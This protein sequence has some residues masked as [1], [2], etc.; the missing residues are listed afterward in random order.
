MTNVSMSIVTMLFNFQLMKI[1]GD[2]GVAAY[3][4]I[5]YA[6][7]S[8]AI[9]ISAEKTATIIR[10]FFSSPFNSSLFCAP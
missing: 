9:V 10:L 7:D 2:N 3:S 1:A 4:A 8:D 6:S 5:A